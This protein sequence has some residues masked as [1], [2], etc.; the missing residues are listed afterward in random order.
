MF[1]SN[2]RAILEKVKVE[3][4][5]LNDFTTNAEGSENKNDSLKLKP[6]LTNE[7]SKEDILITGTTVVPVSKTKSLLHSPSEDLKESL[8]S[9]STETVSNLENEAMSSEVNNS[10]EQKTKKNW[11]IPP[12]VTKIATN[13]YF[14]FENDTKPLSID[15]LLN[16]TNSKNFSYIIGQKSSSGTLTNNRN[17]LN[18][19]RNSP[20]LSNSI[21]KQQITDSGTLSKRELNYHST[22][23]SSSSFP[24]TE[25]EFNSNKI[26][27]NHKNISN[28]SIDEAFYE[29]KDVI[30]TTPVPFEADTTITKNEEKKPTTS[31]NG[32]LTAIFIG[33]LAKNI[34][35]KKLKHYFKEYKSLVSVKICRSVTTGEPL[36]HGYLNFGDEKEA[37]TAVEKYNY[38]PIDG[39]EVRMMQSLR[40][41]FFRKNMGTNVFFSNMP[42]DTF[43]MTTREFYDMFKHYG[44]I[45]SCKLDKR[46]FIGF[47]YFEN[48]LSATKVI[49]DYNNKLF[50]GSVIKCGIHFDKD[51][52]NLP[53]FGRRVSKLDKTKLMK[54]TILTEQNEVVS[55]DLP[56]NDVTGNKIA[57]PN[58]IYIIGLPKSCN[59]DVTLDL[60]SRAGPIKSVH[61]CPKYNSSYR[62]AYITFKKG[63]DCQKA[64]EMFDNKLIK[65]RLVRACK[66]DKKEATEAF[67]E[68]NKLDEVNTSEYQEVFYDDAEDYK[69]TVYLSNLSEVCN[70]GFIT[71]LCR[72]NDIKFKEIKIKWF[73]QQSCAF[74]G[75]VNCVNDQEAAKLFSFMN[76]RLIGDTV[77]ECSWKAN[78]NNTLIVREPSMPIS[79]KQQQQQQQLQQGSITRNGSNYRKNSFNNKIEYNHSKKQHS[80]KNSP[81]FKQKNT[82]LA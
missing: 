7:A 49:E 9:L 22:S 31:S 11:A 6:Q 39:K 14:A 1:T 70:N 35:E 73:D 67:Y 80:I 61:T 64:I 66:A 4:E 51:V 44:K 15:S 32:N 58:A 60:F 38:T 37:L 81:C 56:P 47:I 41:S 75:Y 54:E 79:I 5:L 43:E 2:L 63:S 19:F 10:F 46:K 68:K 33:D 30:S 50:H 77:I 17:T 27:K 13:E 8:S 53:E 59:N 36:G 40:N 28:V 21:S 16:N 78:K 69:A 18:N 72:Q 82:S 29:N 74:A 57:H 42:L 62:Y 65:G 26:F 45:Y 71:E 76:G 48:D 34:D 24:F 52:R 23:S 20:T 25:K 55:P 3:T 12:K